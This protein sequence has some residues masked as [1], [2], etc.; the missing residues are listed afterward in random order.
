MLAPEVLHMEMVS[1]QSLFCT[2]TVT[3][4]GCGA[5][6]NL[7]HGVHLFYHSPILILVKYSDLGDFFIR[8]DCHS[9]N[10]VSTALS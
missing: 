3:L 8:T 10:F 9:I 5:V 2:D 6:K 1:T 7:N 4:I